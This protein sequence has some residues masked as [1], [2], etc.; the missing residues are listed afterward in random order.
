MSSKKLSSS[1]KELR[2]LSLTERS[3]IP[4]ITYA[5]PDKTP[6]LEK[7]KKLT[8]TCINFFEEDLSR[9]N[10]LKH[11]FLSQGEIAP[12]LSQLIRFSLLLAYDLK[13]TNQELFFS[14][15]KRIKKKQ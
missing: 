5:L 3:A 2:D 10:E 11:F 4:E 8:P 6:K 1:L 12:K 13:E 9:I 14:A 15:Y 7:Q